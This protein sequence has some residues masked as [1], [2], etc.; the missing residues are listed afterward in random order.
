MTLRQAQAKFSWKLAWLIIWAYCNGYEITLAESY[1]SPDEVNPEHLRSG[2]HPKRLAADLN[3]FKN[4]AYLNTSEHHFPL[5]LYW[6]SLSE[7]GIKCRWG[8]DF[9]KPD[10]NHYELIQE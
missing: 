5:G 9:S 4:G 8:G 10:G 7:P 3:L 2:Q 6:K 1:E